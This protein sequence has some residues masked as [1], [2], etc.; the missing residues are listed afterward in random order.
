MGVYRL[1]IRYVDNQSRFRIVVTI[2]AILLATVMLC[3]TVALGQGWVAR[4]QKENL[5]SVLFPDTSAHAEINSGHDL[6]YAISSDTRFDSFKIKELGV[7]KTDSS[8]DLPAGLTS[9]P[10][11]NE[12]WVTPAL[13]HL[14]DSNP[15]LQERYRQ[16]SIKEAF[17]SELTVSSASLS[18]LYR[19]PDAVLDNNHAFGLRA[20][21]VEAF[22]GVYNKQK[23]QDNDRFT[24]LRTVLLLVGIVLITPILLLVVETTRIGIVQREKKYATLSL[25]GATNAQMRLFAVVDTLILGVIGT[26]LGALLFALIGVDLLGYIRIGDSTML[27]RDMNLTIGTMLV[28]CG[29]IVICAVIANLQVLRLVKISP[30]E[31]SR[32]SGVIRVPRLLSIVPLLIGVV[33][34]YWFSQFGKSWYDKNTEAGSLILGGL[35]LLVLSGIFIGGPYIIYMLSRLLTRL[36]GSAATILAAYR[37]QSVPHR[38]FRSISGVV[39][40]LFVGALLMTFLAIVQAG[41]DRNQQTLNADTY[42]DNLSLPGQVTIALSHDGSQDVDATLLGQLNGEKR[43]NTLASQVYV[44]KGFVETSTLENTDNI[45]EGK[46]YES[47]GQLA[48]RT[49]LQCESGVGSDIPVVATQQ[50]IT[51]PNGNIKLGTRVTPVDDTAGTIFDESYVIIAKDATS[52]KT[53]VGIAQNI[54]TNYQRSTGKFTAV[55]YPFDNSSNDIFNSIKGIEG[56]IIAMIGVTILI[57]GMSILVGVAGGVFERKKSFIKLRITGVTVG[58]LARSLLAEILIPLVILSVVAVGFGIFCCYCLLLVMGPSGD[59]AMHF[60]F[61]GIIFWVGL[62]LSII[63]CAV[64]SLINIPLLAGVTDFTKIHSE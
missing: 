11:A 58:T 30:L 61:P 9:I 12:L 23:L 63:G 64:V 8:E 35:L 4:M 62:G 46:Y 32:A 17:P 39:I 22:R 14:I 2:L 15:L 7:Y 60:E 31:V 52:L 48:S 37:L 49:T 59:G 41:Y 57:G 55:N 26:V 21:S 33:G 25:V 16:Y 13:K 20:L 6:V 36:T 56:A 42:Q 19:I 29:A 10:S 18:L 28:I 47:C 40:A 1:F 44:Q 5:L 51:D 53:I 3:S 50:F 43:F 45:L 24:M 27:T 54:T 38:V 34:V